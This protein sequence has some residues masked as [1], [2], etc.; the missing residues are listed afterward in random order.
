MAKDGSSL[1]FGDWLWLA[2]LAA[3]MRLVVCGRRWCVHNWIYCGVLDDERKSE[4]IESESIVVWGPPDLGGRFYMM[5]F[6]G[7]AVS[8][9]SVVGDS[10]AGGSS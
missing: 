9:S 4:M 1:W 2:S 8:L 5:Q 3:G 10:A 6:F 7:H